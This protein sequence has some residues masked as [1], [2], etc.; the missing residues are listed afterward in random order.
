MLAAAGFAAGIL[1]AA[2]VGYGM[3]ATST[4]EFCSSC[5]ADN[6]VKEWRESVHYRNS[7]GFV[8]GCAD[9]HLPQ[10]VGP[11]ILRKAKGATLEVWAHF[12][13]V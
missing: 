2:A 7:A 1:A 10:A 13:G 4:N 9:C 11:K 3:H 12:T 6:A 5:H 8:A